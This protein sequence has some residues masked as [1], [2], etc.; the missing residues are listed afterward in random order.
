[1]KVGVKESWGEDRRGGWVKRRDNWIFRPDR[2]GHV[3]KN[4]FETGI[5]ERKKWQ[6]NDS[7]TVEE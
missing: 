3:V 5:V 6:G 2:D 4:A 1:M 7:Y